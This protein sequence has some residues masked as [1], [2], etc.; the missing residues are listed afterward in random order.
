[1][2][3]SRDTTGTRLYITRAR[4]SEIYCSSLQ[5]IKE[6]DQLSISLDIANLKGET[7]GWDVGVSISWAM[8]VGAEEPMFEPEP[9]VRAWRWHGGKGWSV[10]SVLLKVSREVWPGSNQKGLHEFY[11]QLLSQ[12]KQA[13]FG[14]VDE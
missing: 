3:D 10:A 2:G 13:D 12:D 5:V 1:M 11:V 4:A 14:V 9:A 8:I 7:D 6:A